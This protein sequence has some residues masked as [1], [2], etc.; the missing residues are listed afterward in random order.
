MKLKQ[1]IYPKYAMWVYIYTILF[2]FNAVVYGSL[3]DYLFVKYDRMFLKNNE[4]KTNLRLIIEIGLQLG[5]TSVGVYIFKELINF[6]IR[7]YF[8]IEKNPDRFAAA[9]LA[10]VIFAQQPNLMNK[11]TMV[12]ND[13]FNNH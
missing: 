5:M 12:K 4:K 3:L 13:L 11:I 6:I 2:A 8:N 10:P 7:N 1:I 9:I